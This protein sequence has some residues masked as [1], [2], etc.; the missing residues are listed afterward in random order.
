MKRRPTITMDTQRILWSESMGYCMNPDCQCP[1]FQNGT[2]IGEIAH[3]RPHSQS[4]DVSHDNLLILC[5][6][7]HTAIDKNRSHFPDRTLLKWK[8]DRSA[9]VRRQFEIRFHT[10]EELEQ[11]VRPILRRNSQI[12]GSYGPTDANA[13]DVNRRRLWLDFEPELLANNAKLKALFEVNRGLLHQENQET[14]DRF[15]THASEF[16][17]TRETESGHRV[18]LFPQALSAMFGLGMTDTPSPAPSVAALQN[19]IC[20][21]LRKGAFIDLQLTPKQ[22]IKYRRGGSIVKFDLT[23]RP[24]VQQIYFSRRFF[25]PQTTDVRLKDLVFVLE[26]LD[27]QRVEHCWADLTKLTEVCLAGKYHVTF[28]YKYFLSRTDIV[29]LTRRDDLIIVNLYNWNN[30]EVNEEAVAHASAQGLHRL[31][32]REFFKFVRQKLA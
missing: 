4:G 32:Q 23:N 14:V 10:F 30:D 8:S 24:R 17:I 6:T 3:I 27:K 25:R 31:N 29:D 7:C 9:N 21:L 12:F 15:I 13:S 1:L 19:W 28:C 20:H 16:A 18:N 26:W 5:P 22:F 11:E 2:S